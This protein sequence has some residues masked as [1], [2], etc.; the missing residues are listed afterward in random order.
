MKII[1]LTVT[2]F[3][4]AIVKAEVQKTDLKQSPSTFAVK[5]QSKSFTEQE[6]IKNF[7]AE[8]SK[9]RFEQKAAFGTEGVGGG[10]P[11]ED[12]IKEVRD[13]IQSWINKGGPAGLDLDN[14]LT[15][16][17]YSEK[18]SKQISSAK[19]R[20]VGP[21]NDA[22]PVLVYGTP[23]VC[24]FQKGLLKSA[25]IT[26]D[27]D[28]FLKLKDDSQYML[29][30]HEYAGLADIEIPNRDDSDY[31]VSD[32]ITSYL[33]DTIVKRLAVKPTGGNAGRNEW[34]MVIGAE[35]VQL[36]SSLREALNVVQFADCDF[37]REKDDAGYNWSCDGMD[38]KTERY[39]LIPKKNNIAKVGFSWDVGRFF[40]DGKRDS[41]G[42]LEA[43]MKKADGS[44]SIRNLMDGNVWHDPEE[45]KWHLQVDYIVD[46]DSTHTKVD[47]V[48]VSKSRNETYNAGTID[49]PSWQQ[50][51]IP[52]RNLVCHAKQLQ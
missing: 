28:A 27:R 52:I 20:C 48:T 4:A 24:Q 5:S 51:L 43:L 29:V 8:A 3:T 50:R 41:S 21:G 23:K 17:G 7:K 15:V 14:G 35:G 32:Q 6:A 31:Y 2:L 46:L 36:A 33:V 22:Y 42:N 26:C 39:D 44:G 40:C 47:K 49:N 10:D 30:H 38:N 13:D 1:L 18:M 12:K 9:R 19:I 45:M 25:T 11:C 34:S 37:Q 16:I